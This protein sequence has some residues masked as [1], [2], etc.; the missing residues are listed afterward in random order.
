MSHTEFDD[1]QSLEGYLQTM[2]YAAVIPWLNRVG[3]TRV[4]AQLWEASQVAPEILKATGVPYPPDSY[5]YKNGLLLESIDGGRSFREVPHS[6]TWFGAYRHTLLWTKSNIVIALSYAGQAPGRNEA[7][8]RKIGRVSLNG[9]RT[10]VDDIERGTP[11]FNQAKMLYLD[12]PH[13]SEHLYEVSTTPTVE[14]SSNHFL[15]G[16]HLQGRGEPQGGLVAF[17]RSSLAGR[18]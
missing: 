12:P 16:V 10:W 18:S 7:D 17:G 14:L 8:N 5:I 4:S 13:P 2:A 15:T 11:F 1:L 6:L 3:C 9:G